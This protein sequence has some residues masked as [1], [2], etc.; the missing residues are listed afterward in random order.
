MI[1]NS[2]RTTFVN[3]LKKLLAVGRTHLGLNNIKTVANV[4]DMACLD[5]K[6]NLG[7]GDAAQ[8][9]VL[10]G[11]KKFYSWEYSCRIRHSVFCLDLFKICRR[12]RIY[13]DPFEIGSNYPDCFS[14]HPCAVCLLVSQGP[15]D[16]NNIRGCHA[17]RSFARLFSTILWLC[18]I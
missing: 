11:E 14:L 12:V 13:Y 1:K 18:F 8:V 3:F 15:F 5:V 6:K 4:K 10:A 9:N 17:F 7:R 16:A 2:I